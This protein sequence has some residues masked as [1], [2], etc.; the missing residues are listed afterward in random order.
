[1]LLYLDVSFSEISLANFDASGLGKLRHLSLEG[2]SLESLHPGKDDG[3]EQSHW[4]SYLESLELSTYQTMSLR[5][6][7]ISKPVL[8]KLLTIFPI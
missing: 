3:N 8:K 7:K 1:M 4:L 6:V 2:C 5:Y